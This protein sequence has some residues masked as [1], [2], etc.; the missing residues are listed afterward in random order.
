MR[1]TLP[2]AL[3]LAFASPAAAESLLAEITVSGESSP[4]AGY[5]LPAFA[6]F[7]MNQHAAWREYYQLADVGTVRTMPP[8]L[9]VHFNAAF[10][11]NHTELRSLILG[12][13]SRMLELRIS[14]QP[15]ET[16]GF[17]GPCCFMATLI[18]HVPQLGLGLHGYDLTRVTQTLDSLSISGPF[19]LAGQYWIGIGQ[20]TVR[21]YGVTEP[22]IPEP[23]TGLLVLVAC[24]V[25]HLSRCP[26]DR[27]RI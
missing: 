14:D 22:S 24:A 16:D 9:L 20:Q 26:S 15:G 17:W 21:L 18:H 25:L 8:D 5:P 6:F 7:G 23:A 27:V 4:L 13:A 11:S 3:C 1:R 10:D 12:D 19:G 2:L